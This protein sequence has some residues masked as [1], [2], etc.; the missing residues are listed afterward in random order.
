M[1]KIEIKQ[2]STYIVKGKQFSIRTVYIKYFIEE[3]TEFT[4]LIKNMDSSPGVYLSNGKQ[5]MSI[6]DFNTQYEVL[7]EIVSATDRVL[8][9]N[10]Q[11]DV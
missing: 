4:V 2:G 8:R 1:N 6:V 11:A 10:E 3:M 7:E 5:R 9:K